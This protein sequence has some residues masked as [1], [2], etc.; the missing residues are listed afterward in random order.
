MFVHPGASPPDPHA[1]GGTGFFHMPR[2][3]TQGRIPI[4]NAPFKK[5][6]MC[7]PRVYAT[8]HFQYKMR[9]HPSSP[10]GMAWA[11]H[12]KAANLAC[13]SDDEKRVEYNRFC[14]EWEQKMGRIP[15]THETH[16]EVK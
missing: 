1:F 6:A 15:I 4:D 14:T 3:H 16:A 10:F 11:A 13:L 5:H 2:H 8:R 9:P 7:S 12:F